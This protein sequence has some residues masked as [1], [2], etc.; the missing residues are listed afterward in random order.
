MIKYSEIFKLNDTHE[1]RVSIGKLP[2][3]FLGLEFIQSAPPNEYGRTQVACITENVKFYSYFDQNELEK[4]KQPV[5]P[6]QFDEYIAPT[7]TPV[8]VVGFSQYG[9]PNCK[10]DI[11]YNELIH[12]CI[13]VEL[14]EGI[15]DVF[16]RTKFP[17]IYE[18]F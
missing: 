3:G 5:Y 4:I 8:R 15:F 14:E 17:K 16:P 7:G 6:T 11:N 18:I 9:H 1:K 2:M 12:N 10:I 13:H